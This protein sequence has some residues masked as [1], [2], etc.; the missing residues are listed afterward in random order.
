MEDWNDL[1]ETEDQLGPLPSW[2]HSQSRGRDFD[3][4]SGLIVARE[5]CVYEHDSY[6]ESPTRHT[7]HD[8]AGKPRGSSG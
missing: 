3:D 7:T 4:G 1:L 5:N 6:V 2:T 8:T